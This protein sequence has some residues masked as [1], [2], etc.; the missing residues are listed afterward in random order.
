MTIQYV[1]GR[2]CE[3]FPEKFHFLQKF[4]KKNEKP[5]DILPAGKLFSTARL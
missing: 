4:I 3:K 1:I 2:V 5:A